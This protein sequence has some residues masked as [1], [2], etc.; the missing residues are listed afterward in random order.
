[1]KTSGNQRFSDIGGDIG[2][3]WV[4]GF[5][6]IDKYIPKQ[7]YIARANFFHF[8]DLN[9]KKLIKEMYIAQLLMN[10]S[11]MYIIAEAATGGV[12]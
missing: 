2:L 11:K 6:L 8:A 10:L 1:M 9:L 4:N 5:N 7:Q 12:L 3:K